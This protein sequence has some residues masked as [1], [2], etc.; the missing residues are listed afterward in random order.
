[1]QMS[2]RTPA[3]GIQTSIGDHAGSR[4]EGCPH[5]DRRARCLRGIRPTQGAG[6]N[7][8]VQ[9]VPVTAHLPSGP[10]RPRAS[11][12]R[13]AA[14][15]PGR[16]SPSSGRSTKLPARLRPVRRPQGRR[17]AAGSRRG[18][19]SPPRQAPPAW[20]GATLG[21]IG[22]DRRHHHQT[23][24]Q[25]RLQAHCACPSHRYQGGCCGTRPSGFPAC[26]GQVGSRSQLALLLP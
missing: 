4:G 2:R 15:W 10:E 12:R 13:S 17:P 7:A 14:P 9:G 24:E 16:P 22:L 11:L 3:R 20:G 1:M 19:K 25:A 21:Q 5:Q 18:G 6:R 8:G 23:S 26:L